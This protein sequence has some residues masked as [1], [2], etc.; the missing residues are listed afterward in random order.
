MYSL[1]MVFPLMNLSLFQLY[2]KDW[3]VNLTPKLRTSAINKI[4]ICVLK[5]LEYIHEKHIIHCDLKMDNILVNLDNDEC[6][7]EV[8][9]C[10]FGLALQY[11]CCKKYGYITKT[12]D[13]SRTKDTKNNE[14]ILKYHSNQSSVSNC[15]NKYRYHCP[16][17][18]A[19]KEG[20]GSYMQCLPG[21]YSSHTCGTNHYCFFSGYNYICCPNGQEELV[22][23]EEIKNEIECPLSTFAELGFDG[24]H[25]QCKWNKDCKGVNSI[26]HDAVCCASL[27][28]KSLNHK[29][30]LKSSNKKKLDFDLKQID[31]PYPFLTVLN[32]E[33][34][35]ILCDNRNPCKNSNEKC[36]EVGRISICCES[37][38]SAGH[39]SEEDDEEVI[40]KDLGTPELITSANEISLT[41]ATEGST[42][43]I[44]HSQGTEK[45]V[46]SSLEKSTDQMTPAA[47]V[48][49]T[50]Y[51]MRTTTTLRP[52]LLS[53]T[54]TAPLP[55]AEEEGN[56]QI[57]TRNNN[58][59]NTLPTLKPR[60]RA[61]AT[62]TK[63]YD[64]VKL[65]PHTM[66]G[67]MKIN[68]DE[69]KAEKRAKVQEYLMKQIKRGW[70]YDDKFYWPQ[71]ELR[72]DELRT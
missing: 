52:K 16:H 1:Y 20:S 42:T 70:P 65:E 11:K 13:I 41:T 30:S 71:D 50:I 56:A 6:I 26:C 2:K 36:K 63:E 21:D 51:V 29:A 22:R 68:D 23:K 43:S 72:D 18:L 10:D 37:L 35:A 28:K 53:N 17:G 32:T 39:G 31:C 67:Y 12:E 49:S 15:S 58:A 4:N 66:G 14:C 45:T 59:L 60:M 40:Y 24:T 47:E 54:V 5:A 55:V 38:D 25:V 48:Q 62:V 61:A 27:V 64:A 7:T 3:F 8:T 44:V 33:G 69:K 34:S 46:E 9:I 19:R 57:T